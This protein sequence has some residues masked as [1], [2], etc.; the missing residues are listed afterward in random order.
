MFQSLQLAF[1]L[2]KGRSQTLIG[3]PYAAVPIGPAPGC[4]S[5]TPFEL[6]FCGG[7]ISGKLL[8]KYEGMFF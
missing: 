2:F 6:H 8:R 3:Q 4:E 7:T 5:A 1:R